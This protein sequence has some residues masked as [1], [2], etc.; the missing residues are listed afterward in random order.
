MGG[1]R[2]VVNDREVV[3]SEVWI[4][5]HVMSWIEEKEGGLSPYDIDPRLC[6]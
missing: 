2:F 4:Q 3:P 5:V 6:R 1:R